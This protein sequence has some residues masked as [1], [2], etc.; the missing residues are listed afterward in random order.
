MKIAA[1]EVLNLL[2]SVHD[3]LNQQKGM[4]KEDHFIEANFEDKFIRELN[5]EMEAE[6]LT[7]RDIEK[8]KKIALNIQKALLGLAIGPS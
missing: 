2:E 8:I 1:L 7:F 5:S 3:Y 6:V 4:I